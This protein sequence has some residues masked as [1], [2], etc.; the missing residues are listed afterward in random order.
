[1]GI[2]IEALAMFKEIAHYVITATL[3]ICAVIAIKIKKQ[4]IL[5]TDGIFAIAGFALGCSSHL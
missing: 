3:I 5:T 4:D 1:M 2:E